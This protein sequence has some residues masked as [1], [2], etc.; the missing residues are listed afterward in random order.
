MRSVGAECQAAFKRMDLK[1][2]A[3]AIPDE[4]VDEVAIACTPDEALGRLDQWRG[5]T[6]EPLLYAPT[7]GVRPEAVQSNL[8]HILDVFGS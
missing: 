2:L 4:L 1:G 3:D 6:E 8:D 5:L 7:I